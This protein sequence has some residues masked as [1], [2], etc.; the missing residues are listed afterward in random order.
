MSGKIR[1]ERSGA[2]A[3]VVLTRP[4]RMNAM[5]REMWSQLAQVFDGL[6]EDTALRLVV[7]SGEGGHF[8]AGGDIFEYPAFRFD[9]I[10][11]RAFHE[12]DVWGGLSAVLACPVPVIAMIQGNC[13]GAGLEIASCCDI[14]LAAESAR[15]WA[16]IAKLGFPMAP[17]ELQLVASRLGTSV[18]TDLLLGAQVYEA[19]R[20]VATGY[21]HASVPDGE[22]TER[23][24]QRVSQML[25]LSPQAARLNKRGIQALL[26]PDPETMRTW[27]ERAYDY[28]SSAEHREGVSAFLEK[29]LPSFD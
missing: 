23:V 11:L 10:Q 18:A 26:E 8:C 6:R 22:L 29:R 15:F 3:R 16:P 1:L 25:R 20:L 4:A 12:E 28:A 24:E 2:V 17:R 7:V 9:S 19:S 13:M 5:T 21:L 27:V 14:R